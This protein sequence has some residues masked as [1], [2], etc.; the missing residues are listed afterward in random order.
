MKKIEVNEIDL[1]SS[2]EDQVETAKAMQESDENIKIQPTDL[3]VLIE[4]IHKGFSLQEISDELNKKFNKPKRG[5]KKATE[6][7]QTQKQIV[8]L[9]Q[10]IIHPP[11]TV[12]VGVRYALDQKRV[13]E[14][15]ATEPLENRNLL[16]A[17][18]EIYEKI[19]ESLSN[20]IGKS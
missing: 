1:G 15:S 9:L 4:Y 16:T 20:L 14:I 19:L 12:S 7:E 2:T 5:R 18:E 6:E 3:D 8:K 13:L 11:Y 10:P 17:Q